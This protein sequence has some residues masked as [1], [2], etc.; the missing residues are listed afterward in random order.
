MTKNLVGLLAVAVILS[1]G[2]PAQAKE[3]SVKRIPY[4]TPAWGA[5]RMTVR[6]PGNFEDTTPMP[7]V[8]EAARN[9]SSIFGPIRWH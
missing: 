9:H 1:M 5:D 2:A 3:T 4:V 8:D 6:R 7:F